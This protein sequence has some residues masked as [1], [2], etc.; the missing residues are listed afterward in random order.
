MAAYGNLQKGTSVTSY[1]T[2]TFYVEDSNGDSAAFTPLTDN[3]SHA[4]KMWRTAFL[5]D[6]QP[7][8][9]GV[10]FT[11]DDVRSLQTFLNDQFG[12]GSAGGNHTPQNLSGNPRSIQHVAGPQTAEWGPTPPMQVP[13][14]ATAV[15]EWAEQNPME[16]QTEPLA[17]PYSPSPFG[18]IPVAQEHPRRCPV[19]YN[20]AQCAKAEGHHNSQGHPDGHEFVQDWLPVQPTPPTDLQPVYEDH[21]GSVV[22][23]AIPSDSGPA[24]SPDD[25]ADTAGK[26]ERKKSN[27]RKKE[28]KAYDDALTAFRAQPTGQLEYVALT[29]AA[30]ALRT[31]FPDAS[32]LERYDAHIQK[33]DVQVLLDTTVQLPIPGTPIAAE[34]QAPHFAPEPSA[35]AAPQQPIALPTPQDVTPEETAAA[36]AFPCQHV[37]TI[38]QRPCIRAAGHELANPPKP[39]IYAPLPDGQELPVPSFVPP[40]G[41]TSTPVGQPAQDGSGFT[42]ATIPPFQIPQPTAAAVETGHHP[43][44]GFFA[45][46]GG[47]VSRGNTPEEAAA[48]FQPAPVLS[49][50]VPPT[51]DGADLQ[52]PAPAA[53]PW[54]GQQ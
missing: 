44:G 16:R 15:S 42:Q 28:E 34:T 54:G 45:A 25:T 50:Q 12:R 4:L 17:E 31:R 33:Q 11:D 47:Q 29:K 22:P 37:S 20:G 32:R 1:Q 21:D 41:F 27:R 18:D 13:D 26:P 35:A 53:P 46:Q 10:L 19:I 14:I 9:V 23:A 48:V 8:E 43:D 2:L 38:S 39:H 3:G 52:P 49:F 24:F 30:E 6:G 40:T 36:Q 51:P 5:P 7:V